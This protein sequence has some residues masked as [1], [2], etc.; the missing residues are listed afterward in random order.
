MKRNIAI[1]GGGIAGLSSAHY[2]KQLAEQNGLEV[3]LR[4]F[5]SANQVGGKI[6]SIKKRGFLMEEGPESFIVEKPEGLELCRELG[7]A[8]E[9]EHSDPTHRIFYI[10]QA[11]RLVR[12]PA[13]VRLFVPVNFKGLRNTS[14]LSTKAKLR[15]CLE[16]WFYNKPR[17]DD[18]SI[19][20]FIRRHYGKEYEQ[21]IAAPIMA[22]IYGGSP[23]QLSMRA[24]FPKYAM[25][26]TDHG[27]LNR[28][29]KHLPLI[30]AASPFV[31]L[32]GGMQQL[33]DT[34]AKQLRDHIY[35][36]SQVTGLHM[37]NNRFQVNYRQNN[38][39]FGF[40]ADAVVLAT[41]ANF[42][43]ELVERP[44]PE[45]A[46]QLGCFS[47]GSTATINLGYLKEEAFAAK[48]LQGAGFM[49]AIG[50]QYPL[51]GCT[52]A[53]NKFKER[54]GDDHFLF[55]AFIGGPEQD[56]WQAQS[57]DEIITQV[58]EAFRKY[59]GITGTPVIQHVT[60]WENANPLYNIGHNNRVSQIQ[61][62]VSQIP[63]L[64]LTG[65]SYRGV[66]LADCI[67][68][69]KRSAKDLLESLGT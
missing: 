37:V 3:D 48:R 15:A 51:V 30:K 59:M 45:L 11:E 35:T 2:V 39:S 17:S 44:Y 33:S 16:P 36:G 65:S 22:G 62:T 67:R 58:K 26:E 5:E 54:S 40:E 18:E 1:V 55:R 29:I 64:Y 52:W 20:D 21:N 32:K 43:K 24:T 38:E 23:A 68:D 13:G 66:G 63:G 25:L 14:L 53:S 19:S 7:L 57:D 60:R 69:A 10:A 8:Q 34:L 41:P 46:K 56:N 4:L 9:L 31:T 47:Y 6:S 50:N 61:S 27:S 49:S 42:S 12:F 28:G